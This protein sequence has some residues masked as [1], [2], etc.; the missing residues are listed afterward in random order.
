VRVAGAALA[1][2]AYI[3]GYVAAGSNT[4]PSVSI[5]SPASGQKYKVGSTITISAVANDSRGFSVDRVRFYAGDTL[6]GS[7]DR[8]PFRVSWRATRVGTYS[9]TAVA[10]DSG[11]STR[12]AAVD[13]TVEPIDTG[14]TASGAN[15]TV[16]F[17]GSSVTF[18]SVSTSGNTT[19]TAIASPAPGDAPGGYSFDGALAVDVATTATYSGAVAVCLDASSLATN[20]ANFA[21]LRI[22]HGEAGAYVDRTVLAPPPDFATKIICASVPSLSPFVIARRLPPPPPPPPTPPPPP[23]P[24]PSAVPLLQR[25]DLVFE[26][27]FRVPQ[28]P[29]PGPNLNDFQMPL[30]QFGFGGTTLAFNAANNS[31]FIVG[32]DHAQLV[33]EISIPAL[34]PATTLGGLNTAAYLQ[35]FGDVTDQQMININPDPVGNPTATK[36]GGLLAIDNTLYAASYLYYDGTGT[37][38]LSH[39][40]SSLDLSIAHDAAGPFRVQRVDCDPATAANCLGAGFFDGYFGLVPPE[41]RAAFGGPVLNGN[42]CLGVI[43]RTSFGPS[44]FAMDPALLGSNPLPAKPLVYY[45]TQHPLLEPGLTACRVI[46][47]DCPVIVDGWSLTSTL[48]NGTTEIHGV[49]FPQGTRSV[50][51]FGRHGGAGT[52]PD[53]PGNGN[54]CYG[55]GTAVPGDAGKLDPNGV[56][57]LCY[58]LE[59]GSKGVHGYPYR[60]TVWAYDANDLAKVASGQAEPWTARPYAMWSL[61]LPF[62][63]AGLT[64]LGGATY[65]PASGRIFVSQYQVDNGDFGNAN[66]PL[67]NVFRLRVP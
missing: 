60:Y 63:T 26:G 8:S 53:I 7:D 16:P 42:C 38:T 1:A 21:T 49:V 57:R 58:D 48:F 17:G 10:I 41:W 4:P 36:V 39:F 43:G 19:M 59:D 61:D 5:F 23:P 27:A 37:Q 29:N 33:T 13:I 12:S 14:N 25:G 31:L 24:D 67:I 52:S 30:A 45:P 2:A 34:L 6:L 51:F 18:S 22:L 20:A 15:V 44:V 54:F 9:L 64:R 65:D 56:D 55:P 3:P 66:L 47:P 50:L 40:R 32:H 11:L 46:G 35:K 28:T 62:K